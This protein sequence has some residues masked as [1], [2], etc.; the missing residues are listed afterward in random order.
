MF[1]KYKCYDELWRICMRVWMR[2]L[3]E[4]ELTIDVIKGRGVEVG[5]RGGAATPN[6]KSGRANVCF[7]P[8]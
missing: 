4:N 6:M 3:D 1:L 7:P 8:Q 5:V 2:R